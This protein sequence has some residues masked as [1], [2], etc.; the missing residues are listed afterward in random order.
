MAKIVLSPST[1]TWNK[2]AAGLGN[3]H[4]AMKE[5]AVL[6]KPYLE[7]AGHT[8]VIVDGV[9]AR[10]NVAKSNAVNPDAHVALH[11]NAG[12]GK[13]TEIWYY[14]TSAEGK[15]LAAHV[16]ARVAPI[17]SAPDRGIKASTAYIELNSTEAP[18]III[19]YDFHD[20]EAGATEILERKGEYAKATAQGIIDK[21]GTV[22]VEPKPVPPKPPK[23]TIVIPPLQKFGSRGNYVRK[24]QE[25][26]NSTKRPWEKKLK[27]DGIFGG[28]T[29]NAVRDFQR[30]HK[31][32]PD[33]IV[34][35]KTWKVLLTH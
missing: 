27:V 19:E 7:A 31:L 26:I 32:L 14:T 30:K 17:S 20:S 5:I 13:G 9:S 29:E 12:G 33:G 11:S 18:A 23:P 2:Y 22:C 35:P 8:V 1:Q 28:K 10:D 16:Y 15:D 25:K 4:D 24:I 6:T 34:G 21:Y 3:E